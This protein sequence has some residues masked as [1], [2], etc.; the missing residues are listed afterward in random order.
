MNV[1]NQQDCSTHFGRDVSKT[2][3]VRENILHLS[4]FINWRESKLC[5]TSAC[6]P[7]EPGVHITQTLPCPYNTSAVGFTSLQINDSFTNPNS[8][9]MRSSFGFRFVLWLYLFSLAVVDALVYPIAHE[10]HQSI[11]CSILKFAAL[12]QDDHE[13]QDAK[14]QS[15]KCQVQQTKEDIEEAVLC[16]RCDTT[17]ETLPAPAPGS[18]PTRTAA[19]TTSPWTARCGTVAGDHDLTRRRVFKLA[20]SASIFAPFWRMPGRVVPPRALKTSAAAAVTGSWWSTAAQA[21]EDVLLRKNPLTNPMLEQIRIWDQAEA[22]ENKYGGELERGD[23]GKIPGSNPSDK[24]TYY[25]R[26]L[27]PILI[28]ADELK[29]ATE[30]VQQTT[31]STSDSSSME[32]LNEAKRILSQSKYDTIEIKKVFNAFGDNIYYTDPDRAN[33]Y[34]AG[35]ATPKSSQSMA[36]LLRNDILTNVQDMRAEINYLLLPSTSRASGSTEDLVELAAA[37]NRAM[38]EYLKVVPTNEIDQARAMMNQ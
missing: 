10:Q 8:G 16:H 9:I 25:A 23:A 13:T 34:L 37:A 17:T 14:Q 38:I 3:T 31:T 33:L 11:P 7:P 5:G 21:K 22:D 28:M 36:Y 26:L 35:G 6:R 15:P 27:V 12:D 24:K 29:H 1:E 18:I 32:L 20:T 4:N 30:I 19:A 2:T